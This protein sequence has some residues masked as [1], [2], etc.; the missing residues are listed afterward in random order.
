[1]SAVFASKVVVSFA[2]GWAGVQMPAE[3]A[4]V[5]IQMVAN[6]NAL[7]Q[8]ASEKPSHASIFATVFEPPPPPRKKSS[9]PAVPDFSTTRYWSW[10]LQLTVV[11][12]ALRHASADPSGS[13]RRAGR[14]VLFHPWRQRESHQTADPK[15][16]PVKTKN[17]QKKRWV[18]TSTLIG[19]GKGS[20]Q[21]LWVAASLAK[22][23]AHLR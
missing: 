3:M 14:S 7:Q 13:V 5:P 21:G 8:C 4:E 15:S 22:P 19:C 20:D 1:M 6:M 16:E 17:P 23:A 9:V 18:V 2:R 10:V 11:D 12:C